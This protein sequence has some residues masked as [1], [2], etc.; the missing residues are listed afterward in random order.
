M[1]LRQ[2]AQLIM[3]QSIVRTSEYTF[4]VRAVFDVSQGAAKGT[5]NPS[6]PVLDTGVPRRCG[7][8]EAAG[9]GAAAAAG[10]VGDGG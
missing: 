1:R 2:R 5:Y 7:Q 9:A 6:C 3:P 4:Y 10:T 8:C